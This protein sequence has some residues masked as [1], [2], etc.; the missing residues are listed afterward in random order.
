M[1]LMMPIKS[2]EEASRE[3]RELDTPDARTIPIIAL[4]A[5]VT[6]NVTERCQKAGM[7]YCVSK[8]IDPSDLF[9]HMAEEFEKQAM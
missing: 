6:E 8:P 4:T 2:G 7:N 1:D 3:I 9:Y 5:D